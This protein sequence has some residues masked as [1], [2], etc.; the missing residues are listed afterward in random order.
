[1]SVFKGLTKISDLGPEI[2]NIESREC[3]RFFHID[4][5]VQQVQSFAHLSASI[6]WVCPSVVSCLC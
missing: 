2:M 5:Q 1:M 4:L 3:L 6:A